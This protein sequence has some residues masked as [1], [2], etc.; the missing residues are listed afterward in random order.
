[1]QDM[2]ILSS[3]RVTAV[4]ASLV[5]LL[6]QSECDHGFVSL[7]VPVVLAASMYVYN[8]LSA[9][10][11]APVE[12]AS[13]LGGFLTFKIAHIIYVYEQL[14]PK[15]G[16]RKQQKRPNFDSVPD[17]DLDLYGRPKVPTQGVAEAER[18][19]AEDEERRAKWQSFWRR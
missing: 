12:E 6:L 8:T 3:L 14:K 4:H 10:P 9:E 13:L 2:K 18:V 19:L 7:Q 17:I 15:I 11:L 1:M 5:R 16:K